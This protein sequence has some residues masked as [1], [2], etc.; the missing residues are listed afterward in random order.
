MAVAV[1]LLAFPTTGPCQ[2][3]SPPPIFSSGSG[4][5]YF[6]QFANPEFLGA[7]YMTPN[8]SKTGYYP[9]YPGSF[10]RPITEAGI[11]VGPVRLH[12][13]MGIAELYTDNVFRTNAN[14]RSD[15]AT[16]LAPGIQAELPFGRSHSFVADYRTNIQ[17]F[18]QNPSNNVQDQ[19]ASGRFSFNFPGGLRVNLQ[20]EQKLGHDPRG[21]ALDTQ[22]VDVNKW[23][24][25]SVRGQ[26]LYDGANTSIG[27]DVSSMR[28]TYLNNNLGIFRDRLSNYYGVILQRNVSS[29]TSIVMNAGVNQD[30]YD[31]TTALDSTTYR[32]ST[33]L[34]WNVTDLTVGELLAGYQY[35]KFNNAGNG[36]TPQFQRTADSFDNFF[37]MGNM[38]WTPT[39]FL[40]VALQGY[41]SFQQTV[42]FNALF[43]TSTGANLSAV[44]TLTDSTAVTL[45]FGLEHDNF[46]I[47]S[48]TTGS[49]NRVD[50]IKS[51][52]FGVQ[53]RAVKWLGAG[54]QYV[55]EDRD[56]NQDRFNYYANTVMLSLQ[57][58]F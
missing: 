38:S 12:P 40:T 2:Q 42:V 21:S 25:N 22:R 19:T 47:S 36:Q 41:R 28:W 17:T 3:S 10:S 31:Q 20:G 4:W 53:Y 54:L 46:E 39:P 51:A 49:S 44:H 45:N 43:F 18:H 29:K 15:F 34:R 13:M 6:S 8:W 5:L 58:T 50:L 7:L 35:L 26:L 30:L 37:F 14:R 57:A 48:T 32:A 9:L 11:L 23:T 16:T 33:G 1:L 55:F 24:A 52:A 56:S 27:L